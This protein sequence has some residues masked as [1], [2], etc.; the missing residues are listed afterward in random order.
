M[1]INDKS[2][3]TINSIYTYGDR[4]E[5]CENMQSYVAERDAL[6]KDLLRLKNP[7]DRDRV[8]AKLDRVQNNISELILRVTDVW[9]GSEQ[10]IA[11]QCFLKVL[12]E[13][14]E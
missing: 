5:M 13:V 10:V 11:E 14:T 6:I 7:I 2:I 1:N 12:E 3:K 8:S 4:V 9:R